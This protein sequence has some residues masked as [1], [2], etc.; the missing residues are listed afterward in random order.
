MTETSNAE[1]ISIP[2]WARRVG[3]SA[4]SAYKAARAGEIPGCFGIGRLL[5]VNWT[6]FVATTYRS[7]ASE[8]SAA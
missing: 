1:I 3:C 5:R 7:A 8:D 4:D 6:A 2:E